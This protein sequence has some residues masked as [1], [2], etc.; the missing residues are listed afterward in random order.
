VWYA[1]IAAVFLAV[2]IGLMIWALRERAKRHD[3]ERAADK[4][5]AARKEAVRVGDRNA[6]AAE[7]LQAANDR[8]ETQ[9][10]ELRYRVREA[11]KLLKERAPMS[12]IKEWLDAEGQGGE[13]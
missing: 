10:E 7:A 1:I 5:E 11:R 6:D 4:A 3:A 2:G 9:V 12:T 8:L 13:L